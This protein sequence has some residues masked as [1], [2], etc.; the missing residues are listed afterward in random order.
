MKDPKDE[1]YLVIEDPFTGD[2]IEFDL[3]LNSRI[4]LILR[5][6]DK[7][8]SIIESLRSN[9]SRIKELRKEYNVGEIEERSEAII[10]ELTDI[11]PSDF[12]SEDLYEKKL[13]DLEKSLVDI[14]NKYPQDVIDL[15]NK[16]GRLTDDLDKIGVKICSLILKPTNGVP[17]K[18]R[19]KYDYIEEIITGEDIISDIITFFLAVLPSITK[20]HKGSG[21]K[22]KSRRKP[23]Q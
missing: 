17:N 20:Y 22:V 12:E 14:K 8:D 1:L 9:Y 13:N 11:N 6:I 4:G 15:Q 2:D 16:T 19:S 5:L 10:K 18:F 23:D 21:I 7:R 3:E